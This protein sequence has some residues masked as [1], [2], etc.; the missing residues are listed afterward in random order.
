MKQYLYRLYNW[1]FKGI[2]VQK[3]NAGLASIQSGNVLTGQKILVT[4]GSRG[5]GYH[6]AKRFLAEGAKSSLPSISDRAK[7]R[8]RY[9]T[10]LFPRGTRSLCAAKK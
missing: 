9:R 5:I 2:P 8:S 4:G 10:V 3:I 7:K 6:L 1:L